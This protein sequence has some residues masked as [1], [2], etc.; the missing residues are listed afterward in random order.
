MDGT[1][2]LY[3]HLQMYRKSS[4]DYGPVGISLPID[5]SVDLV[6]SRKCSAACLREASLHGLETRSALNIV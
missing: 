5:E 4:F 3:V 1:Q 6:T 2:L